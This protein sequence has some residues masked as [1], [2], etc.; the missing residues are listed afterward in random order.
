VPEAP[1]RPHDLLIVV[2]DI[3]VHLHSSLS[4]RF[5]CCYASCCRRRLG[6]A[7]SVQGKFVP[8]R[9]SALNLAPA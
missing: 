3:D 1:E 7:P 4:A 6:C 8:V 2:A 9:E 5:R